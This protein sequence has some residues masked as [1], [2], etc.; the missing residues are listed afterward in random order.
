MNLK[1]PYQ[2][3]DLPICCGTVFFDDEV[4]FLKTTLNEASPSV[5]NYH[6]QAA[7]SHFLE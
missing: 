6:A 7:I 2:D 3:I 4:C 1:Q 5:M